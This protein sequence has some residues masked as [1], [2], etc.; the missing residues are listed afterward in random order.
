MGKFNQR[1]IIALAVSLSFIACGKKKDSSSVDSA[2]A[3]A[4]KT[5]KAGE[6][7]KNSLPNPDEGDDKKN[8]TW[9]GNGPPNNKKPGETGDEDK[10][11]NKDKKE[12]SN[13]TEISKEEIAE[14]LADSQRYS[15]AGKD[16]LRGFLTLVQEQVKDEQQRAK[17]LKLAYNIRKP[18]LNFNYVTGKYHAS[19]KIENEKIEIRLVGEMKSIASS[20]ASTVQP[21]EATLAC[22]DSA[23]GSGGSLCETAVVDLT[24]KK[25]NAKIIFR[26]TTVS[27]DGVFPPRSC[28]TM[29]C[30]KFYELLVLSERK[31]NH[32]NTLKSA[33]METFEVVQ[34][35]SGFKMMALTNENQVIKIAGPLANP[36][37]FP[38]LNTPTERALTMEEMKDPATGVLRITQIHNS[39][40]EVQIIR[41]SGEGDLV[42]FVN[43]DLQRDGDRD[44]FFLKLNRKGHSVRV[45]IQDL[46]GLRAAG[47]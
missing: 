14:M 22:M 38:E 17:N 26:T 11:S 8:E 1:V 10:T 27:L 34:G 45:L 30:E 13:S 40:K 12:N 19:L 16:A 15:G 18:V 39:L 32:S 41:N 47:L 35:S 28:L 42:L 9:K 4:D 3:V 5:P 23:A 6:Q 21:V 44:H 25:A 37:M 33:V 7:E 29:E 43:M 46:T 2:P 20:M 24:Y 31:S 36:Q